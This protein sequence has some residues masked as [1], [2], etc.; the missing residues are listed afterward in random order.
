MARPVRDVS[1]LVAGGRTMELG[2]IGW[3]VLDSIK[4][5]SVDAGENIVVV[6]HGAA[7]GADAS[8]G[9]WAASRGIAVDEHPAKWVLPN[10]SIDRS[11]GVRRSAEMVA[12]DPDLSVIF[13]G[14]A[15]T[16]R[17][18]QMLVRAG[19]KRMLDL[20]R[21]AAVRPMAHAD[22]RDQVASKWARWSDYHRQH[23]GVGVGV[24]QVGAFQGDPLPGH[25]VWVGDGPK[26]GRSRLAMPCVDRQVLDPMQALAEVRKLWKGENSMREIVATG[27]VFGGLIVCSCGSRTCLAPVLGTVMTHMRCRQ[28]M[29]SAGLGAPDERESS[30]SLVEWS[31]LGMVAAASAWS[32]A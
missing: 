13:P 22:V 25:A 29:V 12:M 17:T 27:E 8:A 10:G 1:L 18:A 24:A 23:V 4:A 28:A 11:A 15:G 16:D 3:T 5:G 6:I 7:D 14:N 2:P 9:R 20:R 19:K 26:L 32:R 31:R 21:M 30:R